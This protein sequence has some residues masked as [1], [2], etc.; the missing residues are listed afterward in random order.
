MHGDIGLP[1]LSGNPAPAA[2]LARLGI[3]PGRTYFDSSAIPDPGPNLR[4][5][6][7]PVVGW[8]LDTTSGDL[9]F[10]RRLARVETINMAGK[11]QQCWAFA[12]S[13]YWGGNLLGTGTTWM[14]RTGLVRHRSEWSGFVPSP[15]T[16]GTLFRE[17]TAP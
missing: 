9:R 15:S 10:V 3:R 4:F 1:F 14:G 7:T 16:A 8:R 17:I 6:E 12:E 2:A 11:R 13:T 5:P